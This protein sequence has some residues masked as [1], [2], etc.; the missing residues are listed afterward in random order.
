[1]H[2]FTIRATWLCCRDG[3]YPSS[4]LIGRYCGE[5][6]SDPLIRSHSNRMFLRFVSD[7][8]TSASGFRIYYDGTLSGTPD[9]GWERAGTKKAWVWATDVGLWS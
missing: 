7:A 2:E 9:K 4:P 6:M 8:S 5:T 3:G 1:M